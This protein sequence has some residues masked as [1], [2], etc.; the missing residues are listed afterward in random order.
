MVRAG[1]RVKKEYN[2]TLLFGILLFRPQRDFRKNLKQWL[3]ISCPYGTVPLAT[4]Y[5]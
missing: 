4:K 2:F 3:Q 5:L 1:V